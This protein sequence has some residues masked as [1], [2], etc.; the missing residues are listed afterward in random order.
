[1]KHSHAI[2]TGFAV[3]LLALPAATAIACE[4]SASAS[5]CGQEASV[6]VVVG[7][8]TACEGDSD[9]CSNKAVVVNI[10]VGSGGSACQS[11][12][13]CQGN[14]VLVNLV[15]AGDDSH[16]CYDSSTVSVSAGATWSGN[17]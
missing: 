9:A 10:V 4:R 1:M 7:P 13:P 2:L 16:A 15:V 17:L 3:V 8:A 14:T 6:S 5:T 12:D 11:D